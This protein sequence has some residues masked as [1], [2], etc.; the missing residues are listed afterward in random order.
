[1]VRIHAPHNKRQGTRSLLGLHSHRGALSARG[2]SRFAGCGRGHSGSQQ[3]RGRGCR[4]CVS[5]RRLLAHH[6]QRCHTAA[7]AV[8]GCKDA[9][10]CGSGCGDTTRGSRD[11]GGGQ[12]HTIFAAGGCCEDR[13]NGS[14][15]RGRG[16]CG[17]GDR[18]DG[19]D[20]GRGGGGRCAGT[21]DGGTDRRPGVG[22]SCDHS[23][24]L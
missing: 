19:C 5:R 7:H 6:R 16:D 24:R 13:L 22:H 14:G 9:G 8:A 17:S 18:A 11:S 15:E 12:R 21:T 20:A 3:R 2:W 23:G 1:M 4:V 10:C